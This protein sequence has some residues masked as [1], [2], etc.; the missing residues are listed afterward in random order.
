MPGLDGDAVDQIAKVIIGKV[1]KLY[2]AIAIGI[3]I[4]TMPLPLL[5]EWRSCNPK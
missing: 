2:I 3:A 5:Y 1:E 4:L